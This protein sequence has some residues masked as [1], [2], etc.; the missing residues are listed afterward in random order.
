MISKIH[1]SLITSLQHKKFR[2]EHSLFIAEGEKV[3]SDLLRS[4]FSVRELYM[5][6]EF[7]ENDFRKF[8]TKL[9]PKII[10][11]KELQK[12]SALTTAQQV[13]AVAEIPVGRGDSVD[14]K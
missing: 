3:V 13:L 1:I 7:Y 9:E 5:T 12:I 11:E 4:D 2:K 6:E 14:V 10:S 8:K